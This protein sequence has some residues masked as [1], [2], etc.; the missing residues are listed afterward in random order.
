MTDEEFDAFLAK[1]NDELESKQSE[2]NSTY[3]L[4]ATKRCWF[5]QNEATFQFFDGNDRLAVARS[6]LQ[7][8]R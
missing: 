1:V 4:G 6:R 7:A 8:D 2:P 5:E 3:G